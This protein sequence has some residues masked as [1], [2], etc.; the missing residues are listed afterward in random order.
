MIM[1]LSAGNDA[2]STNGLRVLLIH[3]KLRSGA[4]RVQSQASQISRKTESAIFVVA[5]QESNCQP[6]KTRSG[7]SRAAPAMTMYLA[8]YL[9]KHNSTVICKF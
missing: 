6:R 2:A 9:R 3:R 7:V 4:Q 8:S 1:K 5:I